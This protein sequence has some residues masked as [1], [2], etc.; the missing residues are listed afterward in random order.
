MSVKCIDAGNT[1]CETDHDVWPTDL[2]PERARDL[3]D[4]HYNCSALECVATIAVIAVLGAALPSE[5]DG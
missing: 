4:A 1:L 5:V 3:A 2:T